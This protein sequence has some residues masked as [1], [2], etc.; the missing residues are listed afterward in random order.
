MGK[1]IKGTSLTR[2]KVHDLG[3][4]AEPGPHPSV[5]HFCVKKEKKKSPKL[6]HTKNKER[7]TND[8]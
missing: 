3:D 5:G 1:L 4:S 7:E 2:D 6:N 8:R